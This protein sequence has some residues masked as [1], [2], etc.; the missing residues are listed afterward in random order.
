[1]GSEDAAEGSKATQSNNVNGVTGRRR[2]WFGIEACVNVQ[3]QTLVEKYEGNDAQRGRGVGN[4][5]ANVSVGKK[6]KEAAKANEA[7]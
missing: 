1:M 3:A 4:C 7:V 5:V 2:R 6:K